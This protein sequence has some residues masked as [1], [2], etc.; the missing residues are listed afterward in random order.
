ML[1]GA[2]AVWDLR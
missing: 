1:T 2:P